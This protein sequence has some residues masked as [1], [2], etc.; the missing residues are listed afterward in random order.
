MTKRTTMRMMT[1]VLLAL[2]A[3]TAVPAA[4]PNAAEPGYDKKALIVRRRNLGRSEKFRIMVDKVVSQPGPGEG[5]W[6]EM[7]DEIFQE[8][9]Q[10]GFN[11]VVPRIGGE[12][13]S[14]VRRTAHGAG[15]NGVFTM[16]WLRGTLHL[17]DKGERWDKQ[18]MT[19]GGGLRQDVYSPNMDAIWD[20]ITHHVVGCAKI[21]VDEPSLIGAFLDYE[22]YWGF[23][24]EGTHPQET[25]L[26]GLSYDEKI[27]G[28]FAASK[29]IEMPTL[30]LAE[31]YPWLVEKGLDKEFA[32]FQIASWRARCRKLRQQIDEVN[33]EF[34]LFIYPTPM[35]SFF[36]REAACLE[37][38]TEKAPYIVADWKTYG[39]PQPKVLPQ[40]QAMRVLY[41]RLTSKMKAM[42]AYDVRHQYI[43]GIDP[44][45]GGYTPARIPALNNT[46]P[47]FCGR[48]AAM[49]SETCNGYW[50]FYEGPTRDKP[51]HAAYMEWF[52]R[53]NRAIVA[54]SD[55]FWKADRVTPDLVDL[56]RIEPKT[57]KPQ[58]TGKVA[59][60]RAVEDTGKYEVHPFEGATLAYLQQ[61]DAIVLVSFTERMPAD[62]PLPTALRA[63]VEQGG[64][65]LVGFD[66]FAFMESP[67]PEFGGHGVPADHDRIV[68][69]HRFAYVVD[70][71]FEVA[72]EHPALGDLKAG[73]RYRPIYGK[74]IIFEAGPQAKVLMRDEFGNAV[75]A[76]ATLGKGRV[77]FAGSHCRAPEGL[78]KQLYLSTLTWVA[79]G[80]D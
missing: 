14:R 77:A 4:E 78:E 74:H 38:G 10:A 35:E 68:V 43:S 45:L 75:Y 7:S 33:P 52:T 67:F 30:G 1:G 42:R 60:A 53:A 3:T 21:S 65:L 63:Y 72:E 36:I 57:D 41:R 32:A 59:L 61:F 69:N 79:G 66:T 48:N 13:P 80:G 39:R 37:F 23:D 62:S 46:D 24:G 2:V 54:G 51:D 15:K 17:Y 28:E 73:T 6:R 22:N 26:Y 49:I 50:V 27:L 31:R 55:D 5:Q 71:D 58:I 8:F 16:A 11:V 47:E 9:A 44:K 12:D 76:V 20:H 29:G 19:W 25:T 40:D 34:Q 18:R 56:V 64:G 70:T